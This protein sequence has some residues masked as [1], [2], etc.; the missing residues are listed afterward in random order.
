MPSTTFPIPAAELPLVEANLSKCPGL[1]LV[2]AVSFSTGGR[3]YYDLFLTY[4]QESD[5]DQL[6]SCVGHDLHNL[7]A[8][9]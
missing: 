9:E 1:T 3:A 4:T 7:Q 8:D 2:A 5:L 6:G